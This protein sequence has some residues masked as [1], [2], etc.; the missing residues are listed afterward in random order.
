L[1]AILSLSSSSFGDTF[2]G[3][4]GSLILSPISGDDL[5]DTTGELSSLPVVLVIFLESIYPITKILKFCSSYNSKCNNNKSSN[6][7]SQEVLLLI[8]SGFGVTNNHSLDKYKGI[9]GGWMKK[10]GRK[11]PVSSL[12][13][14]E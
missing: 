12:V 7:R 2:C 4:L 14:K 3:Q 8:R 6:S 5:R 13:E 11:H 9:H 1:C 10:L